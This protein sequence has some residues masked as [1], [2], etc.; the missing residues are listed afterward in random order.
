[1]GKEEERKGQGRKIGKGNSLK[2]NDSKQF[3][4]LGH[5][6]WTICSLLN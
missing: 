1:M 6:N 4:T 3:L 5:S 2:V